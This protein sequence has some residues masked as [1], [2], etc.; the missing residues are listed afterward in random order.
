MELALITPADLVEYTTLLP[1]RFCIGPVA[2]KSQK[3]RDF[4][5]KS[6]K[7]GYR[8]IL[9]NGAFEGEPLS[10]SELHDLAVEIGAKV[11]I[12]PDI[13]G[14]DSD[15]SFKC[16]FAY[17]TLTTAKSYEIMLVLQTAQGASWETTRDLMRLF[18]GHPIFEWI[19][20]PRV[21]VHNLFAQYVYCAPQELLRFLFSCRVQ[22]DPELFRV[23]REKKVHFLGLGDELFMLPHFW[24]V[25]SIDT[26]SL[27]W[28]AYVGNTVSRDG[29]LHT[30]VARPKDYFALTKIPDADF[31]KRLRYNCLRAMQ[32]ASAADEQ[33]RLITGSLYS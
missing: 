21:F 20:V 26:A 28:Q 15:E 18:L 29:F 17:A 14:G 12:A 30:K 6:A 32:F 2:R 25:N 7:D 22:E 5:K 1:G 8:V 13:Y 31:E 16:S 10:A 9:D 33:R 3:Y 23:L 24:W 11:V 27:F 4:F 19:G